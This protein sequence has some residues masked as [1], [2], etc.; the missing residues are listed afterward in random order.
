V[1]RR[2]PGTSTWQR[3]R[4]RDRP[5]RRRGPS[6]PWRSHPVRR[7]TS[8]S[9]TPRH[10]SCET[11][12]SACSG[13]GCPYKFAIEVN[14]E[15]RDPAGGVRGD[16]RVQ[17]HRACPKPPEVNR[18]PLRDGCPARLPCVAGGDR[19]WVQDIAGVR[20]VCPFVS[21]V[22]WIKDV[23][24]RQTDLTTHSRSRTT[25]PRPNR[26]AFGDCTS[27]SRSRPVFLSDR[28]NRAPSSSSCAPWQ[29]GFWA[30][31]EHAIY[32]NIASR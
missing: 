21:D 9:S 13:S 32:Y 22:Y 3:G 24:T 20:V 8:R 29:W 25:S 10:T 17:S 6:W 30:N 7:R 4:S 2:S 12:I 31:F 14:H 23:L 28:T 26:T 1:A 19:R 16:A 15:A 11:R 18:Q 27:R 5:R